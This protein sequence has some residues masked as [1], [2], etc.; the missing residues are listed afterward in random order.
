VVN[1]LPLAE[2]SRKTTFSDRGQVGQT[3]TQL[4]ATHPGEIPFQNDWKSLSPPEL[5][6]TQLMA[7][8]SL[9]PPSAPTQLVEMQ[10]QIAMQAGL[11]AHVLH[12]V[13]HSALMHS[14]HVGS[15]VCM[16]HAT[17]ASVEPPEPA[18]SAPPP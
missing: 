16:A 15:E 1:K 10:V 13:R 6:M 5:D 18:V 12:S 4:V 2:V 9:V 11:S 7:Q 17:P 14:S 3:P 8:L